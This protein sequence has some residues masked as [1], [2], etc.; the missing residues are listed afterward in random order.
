MFL[1]VTVASLII[2]YSAWIVIHSVR[3]LKAAK[4]AGIPQGCAGCS[5][6][7]TASCGHSCYT[8]ADVEKM[9]ASA[10]HSLAQKRAAPGVSANAVAATSAAE[11]TVAA[12]NANAGA[13]VA[14]DASEKS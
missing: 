10:R 3:K 13:A 8:K 5:A 14:A 11:N 4:A 7:D 9:A 12:E 6:Y 2:A 1:T